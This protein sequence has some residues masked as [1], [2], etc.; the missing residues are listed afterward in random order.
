[1]IDASDSDEVPEPETY[2]ETAEPS[3]APEELPQDA[4]DAQNRLINEDGTAEENADANW[5]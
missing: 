4:D 2:A 1:M 5:L 3:E